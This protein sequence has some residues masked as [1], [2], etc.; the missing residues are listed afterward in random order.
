[1]ELWSSLERV[2]LIRR[3]VR[4][5]EHRCSL[6]AAPMKD[7]LMWLEQYRIFWDSQ[8]DALDAYLQEEMNRQGETG[9]AH[10]APPG[11]PEESR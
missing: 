10:N 9:A 6:L 4:G 7:A 8:M 5:R 3:E 11:G 2:G 1:M